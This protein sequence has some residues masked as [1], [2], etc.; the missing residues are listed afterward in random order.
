MGT[1]FGKV[2][3]IWAKRCRVEKSE[4]SSLSSFNSI[5]KY[6]H[7]RSKLQTTTPRNLHINMFKEELMN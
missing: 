4:I 1:M 2:F 6:F 3:R 7:F 5:W